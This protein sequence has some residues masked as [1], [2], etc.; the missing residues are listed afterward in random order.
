MELKQ[1]IRRTNGKSEAQRLV[2]LMAVERMLDSADE[3]RFRRDGW[4]SCKRT[5]FKY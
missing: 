2:L 3:R 5:L 1:A 4:P